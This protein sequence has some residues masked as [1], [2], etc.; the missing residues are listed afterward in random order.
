M[1]VFS[2]L[3]DTTQA[4]FVVFCDNQD[5]E[6]LCHLSSWVSLIFEFSFEVSDLPIVTPFFKQILLAIFDA[7]FLS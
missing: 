6:M 1:S 3:T 4:V 5:Q 2:I 7:C